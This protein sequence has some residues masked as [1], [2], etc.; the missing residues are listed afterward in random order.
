M[1]KRS[2]NISLIKG[3]IKQCQKDIFSGLSVSANIMDQNF[4]YA[5]EKSI[6]QRLS[7]D[8]VLQLETLMNDENQNTMKSY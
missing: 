7:F 1:S 3:D 6:I 5:T 8:H 4:S 2:S